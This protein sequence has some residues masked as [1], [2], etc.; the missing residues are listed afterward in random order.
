LAESSE[1]TCASARKELA[2]AEAQLR[3]YQARL[4]ATFPY[5][6]YLSQLT[7]LRDELKI[8]LSDKPPEPGERNELTVSELAEQIKQLKASHTIEATPERIGSRQTQAE[9]P[10]TARIRRR[11]EAKAPELLIEPYPSPAAHYVEA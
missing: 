4:G 3:G 7:A 2:I 8:R 5:D 9:E 1:A 10:V 11:A 6:S